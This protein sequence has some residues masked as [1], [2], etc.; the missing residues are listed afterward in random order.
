MLSQLVT[1]SMENNMEIIKTFASGLRL[2]ATHMPTMY[3]VSCGIY[4]DVGSVREDA[5]TNGYSHFLEHLMF[6]GTTNR[7]YTEISEHMDDIGAQINAFTSKDNTCYYTKS[8]SGDIATCLELLSDLYFNSTFDSAE[9]EK[10]KGVVLEEIAVNNDNPEDVAQDLIGEAI[11][12]NQKLAQTILGDPQVIKNSTRQSL[13]E[14]RNRFYTPANTVI[15]VAGN[16]DCSSIV[17]LVE[18][19]FEGQFGNNYPTVICE[20]TATATSVHLSAFK[21]I[22]QAHVALAYNAL[23]LDSDKLHTLSLMTNILGGGMSSRLFQVIREQHGLAYSVYSYPSVYRNNGF[24]EIYCG[25]SPNNFGNLC[26]LLDNI[27]TEFVANGISEKELLR[28]KAQARNGLF[29]SMEST[30][31]AMTA[32]GRRMLKIGQPFDV[33]E[34]IATIDKV[35]VDDVNKMAMQIFSQ[36]HASIYV[37]KQIDNH[38][39]IAN[40]FKK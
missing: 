30:L 35:S 8:A 32:H 23:P 2:V 6:K 20:E 15:S 7:S 21:D 26:G 31:S 3:T 34:R 14:Y 22:E 5:S 18:Q 13:L 40:I 11:Y 17:D 37:G 29:M 39:D 25:S 4:I 33:A 16:F 36:S 12:N 27:L 28:A 24:V 9:I 38:E 1:I 19:Y 10:E